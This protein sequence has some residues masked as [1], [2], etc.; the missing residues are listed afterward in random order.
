MDQTRA[1]E[2]ENAATEAGN[3]S[4]SLNRETLQDLDTPQNEA[5]KGG[6]AVRGS[7]AVCQDTDFCQ[8]TTRCLTTW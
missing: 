1:H 4:L 3:G 5:V 6:L 2:T 7:I 8:P